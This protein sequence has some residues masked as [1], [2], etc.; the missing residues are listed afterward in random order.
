[1]PGVYPRQSGGGDDNGSGGGLGGGPMIVIAILAAAFVLVIG[2]WV[3]VKMRRSKSQKA[4]SKRGGYQQTSGND[5][6]SRGRQPPRNFDAAVAQ[7]RNNGTVDRHTSIRSIMTLPAY[8]LSPNE[9]ERTLGREGERDG[10]DVVVELQTAENEEDLREEEMEALYRIRAARRAQIIER[11][12]RRRQRREARARGDMVALGE[13][14]ERA[15]AASSSSAVSDL[16]ADHERIKTQRQRA[17]SS[18][19]YGDL[20]VA[21]ADG[22]RIRANSQESERVGL[23]SDAASIAL[24]T[25]SRSSLNFT[26]Q[27]GRST[28]STS[29]LSFDSQDFP[30]PGHPRSEATTPRRMSA[31][32]TAGS[33]PEIISEADLGDA[34]IPPN[35]PPGYDNVSLDDGLSGGGRSGATTP[36]PEPPPDYPGPNPTEER[37]LRLSQQVADMVDTVGE[38]GDLG[39][40]SDETRD[41]RSSHRSSRSGIPQLPS[42]RIRELPQIVVEP[43]SAY[44]SGE[45]R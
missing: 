8:R 32:H 9:N 40:S 29:V 35:S 20:G 45:R 15:R 21:R 12:E 33:S 25:Q 38:D 39:G 16:Q 6:S 10:V 3:F 4:H 7:S 17:V 18:V 34:E 19:S 24:S 14:A 36:F 26:H 11:E 42:L 43:S 30:S 13:I 27:R 37:D 5:D 41:R 28:S 44:P 1:M 22:S 31:Q 2:I 23:L